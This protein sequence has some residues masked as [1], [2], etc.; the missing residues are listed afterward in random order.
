MAIKLKKSF[1]V[2]VGAVVQ[3]ATAAAKSARAAVQSKQEADFQTAVS[4]GMSYDAQIAFRQE[5]INAEQ[6][7]TVP[8]TDYIA[9][10]QSSVQSIQ[11]LNRFTKYRAKY[12]TSFAALKAGT[13]TAQQH[14]DLLNNLLSTTTDPALREEIQSNI[15]EASAEVKQNQDDILQNQVKKAQYDGTASILSSTIASIKD[16]KALATLHGDEDQASALDVTLSVLNQQL[17]KVNVEDVMDKLNVAAVSKGGVSPM[18]KLSTLNNQIASANNTDPVTIDGKTYDSVA[19]YW[20]QTRDAYLSGNGSGLF[21]DFF[22]ELSNTY[23]DKV[24]A[25]VARD[26]FATTLTLDGIKSETDLLKS[27]P[28]LAPFLDQV[29]NLQAITLAN[30]FDTTAKTIIARA[31]YTGDFQGADTALQN[32]STKYGVDSQSYRL[33]LG[34]QLTQQV[35][36]AASENHVDEATAAKALGVDKLLQPDQFGIPAS[37]TPPKTPTRVFTT[38]ENA[39]LTAANARIAAGTASAIDKQNVAY[40]QK[41]GWSAPTAPTT[42]PSPTVTPTVTPAVPP[43]PTPTPPTNATPNPNTPPAQTST[44]TPA[45]TPAPQQKTPTPAAP[46]VTAAAASTAPTPTPKP[47]AT[48]TPAPTPTQTTN[49]APS[50]YTG[51]SI[52]DYLKSVNQ[53]S[54]HTNLSKL[55]ADNGITNYSGTADQ[56]TTLLKKLR[57]F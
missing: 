43:A 19:A 17:N 35:S 5:Q 29:N 39:D 3:N 50:K 33:T 23:S 51:V 30:A 36:K 53:D 26:G 8:D 21:N 49:P 2:N 4:N 44:P 42:E 32:Y 28:E 15:V 48:P 6:S 56:N 20:T 31:A 54:S 14:L 1:L 27:K 7:S 24:N 12:Q 25:A 18:S 38:K 37:P 11:K 9:Q 45:S 34:N 22:K 57:G 16:K 10:L 52:V 47:V 55:A 46:A 13:E 40:A 41:Q